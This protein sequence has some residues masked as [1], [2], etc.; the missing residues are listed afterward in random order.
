MIDL[1][2]RIAVGVVA[3]AGLAV[4]TTTALAS[5]AAAK[6]SVLY[7][8]LVSPLPGNLPSVG[9]EA[10]SF[11]EFGNQIKLTNAGQLTSVVVTMSSWA[12]QT[13]SW[14]T[15][16]CYT[17]PGA[18]FPEPITLNLYHAN[19]PGST[20]PGALILSKTKTFNIPYRPSVTAKCTLAPY[21]APYNGGWGSSCFNGKAVNI[22]FTLNHSIPPSV[23]FGITYNTSD[24]GYHPYGQ[25]TLCFTTPE[26]CPY[27][28]LNIALS[29][30]ATRGNDPN[31]GTVFQNALAGDYCDGGAA[32][33]GFFRLELRR[34]SL[35]AGASTLRTTAPPSTSR[36]CSS[37]GH[38]SGPR[39]RRAR[40]PSA[41]PCAPGWTAEG[42]SGHTQSG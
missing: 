21:T 17:K 4:S 23:V 24:Y 31:T 37:T 41:T 7:S 40:E 38:R 5:N 9:A 25:A 3:I 42:S 6:K 32:G 16:N 39:L 28:S 22:T 30:K 11:N 10:Y 35:R 13:G 29:T 27:N 33:S 1:Q 2:P 8:S 18:T 36:R 12:C 19:A 34:V 20:L 15:M 26:G 14:S